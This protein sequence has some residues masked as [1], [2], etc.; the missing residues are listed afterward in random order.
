MMKYGV[1]SRTSPAG[2]I[3]PFHKVAMCGAKI[4]PCSYNGLYGRKCEHSNI[5]IAPAQ[6]KISPA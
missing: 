4:N 1:I 2:R 5:D 3:L 6:N